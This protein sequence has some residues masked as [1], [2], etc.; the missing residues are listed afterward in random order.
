[1][2]SLPLLVAGASNTAKVSLYQTYSEDV[3][4]LLSSYSCRTVLNYCEALLLDLVANNAALAMRDPLKRL[5]RSL[6]VLDRNFGMLY[7][8]EIF[9]PVLKLSLRLLSWS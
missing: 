2:A 8:L 1:M 9:L 3:I 7:K 4:E 6:K 5:Y